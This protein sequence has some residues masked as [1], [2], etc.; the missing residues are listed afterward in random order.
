[1]KML[2]KVYSKIEREFFPTFKSETEINNYLEIKLGP[3]L[4]EVKHDIVTHETSEDKFW[5]MTKSFICSPSKIKIEV[6]Q[7]N[8][9]NIQSFLSHFLIHNVEDVEKQILNLTLML[10]VLPKKLHTFYGF[11]WLQMVNYELLNQSLLKFLFTPLELKEK[12]SWENQQNYIEL[13]SNVS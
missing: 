11:S 12:R 4:E 3:M 1:M 8:S 2:L 7:E 6:R 5:I 10:R 13:R 9:L